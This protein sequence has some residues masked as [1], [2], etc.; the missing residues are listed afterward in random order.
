[1]N[2]PQP[3][4]LSA[5]VH[6]RLLNL[7]QAKGDNF[8]FLLIRYAIERLLYR[9]SHSAHADAFVLKGALLFL[10]WDVPIHRPTRDIDLL[11]FE[12]HTAGQLEQIFR[13]ICLVDVVA[14]GLIFD[15]AT[16]QVRPIREEQV[17]GGQRVTLTAYLGRARI[18][19]Q[20]DI[21]FGDA[22]V[23]VAVTTGYPTLLDFPSPQIQVYP[24]ESVVAEKLHAMVALDMSNSQMKDFFDIWILARLFIFDGT[25]LVQAFR[26]TFA[27][28]Q[29][30]L[31]QETPTAFL[32]EFY[33]D[34][35]KTAQ[36]Q[37]FVR[38]SRIDTGDTDLAQII[39][40]IAPFLLPPLQAA[41]QGISFSASWQPNG[42]WIVS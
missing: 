41:A 16:I 31:P 12:G 23:P 8:N 19:L 36:W 7:S 21:G 25:L 9:L 38:R 1:M 15:P 30:P 29:T 5:S 6:Q 26:S 33:A 40:E 28:R 2:R 20:I 3:T 4:N 24:R 14:D 39:E 32:P 10:V 42:P 35:G 34:P 11:G 18:P 17:N 27:E 13:D 22:V 37:A